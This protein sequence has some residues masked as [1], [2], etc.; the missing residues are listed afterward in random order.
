MAKKLLELLELIFGTRTLRLYVNFLVKLLDDLIVEL[1]NDL[2]QS[3][4]LTGVLS[5]LTAHSARIICIVRESL[6]DII[7]RTNISTPIPPS[8]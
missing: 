6:L 8:Q 2:A 1:V 3:V 4:Y 7:A 5:R